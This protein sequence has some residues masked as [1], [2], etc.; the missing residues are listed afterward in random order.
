[1]FTANKEQPHLEAR[2]LEA[3][4]IAFVPSRVLINPFTY[5]ESPQCFRFLMI[6]AVPSLVCFQLFDS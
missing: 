3:C 6:I 5:Y 2:N 1:M 4:A